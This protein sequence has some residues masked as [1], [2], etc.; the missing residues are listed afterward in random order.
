MAVAKAK[1]TGG[2]KKTE[3]KKSPTKAQKLPG[4]KAAN[5]GYDAGPVTVHTTKPAKPA[6]TRA[7]VSKINSTVGKPV[8]KTTATRKSADV[9]VRSSNQPKSQG[10]AATGAP[11]YRGRPGVVKST[12][13]ANSNSLR[14][15]GV[16]KGTQ[17]QKQRASTRDAARGSTKK[18]NVN[19]RAH[20]LGHA[21]G[22]DH[23][24]PEGNPYRIK[25]LKQHRR[26]G[27]MG[28]GS[29]L[30]TNEVKKIKQLRRTATVAYQASKAAGR[31]KK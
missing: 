29:R 21:I 2:K 23:P 5:K 9:V 3:P 6:Y 18:R 19:V 11:G 17:T 22:L 1:G 4:A 13:Q 30:T 16:G 15:H 24:G 31:K 27:I 20:E 25:S 10:A 26:G 12:P 8:F 14:P 7:A 28:S